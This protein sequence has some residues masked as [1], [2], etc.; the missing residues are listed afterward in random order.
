MRVPGQFDA[1]QTAGIVGRRD[2]DGV[3]QG[4]GG[5]EGFGAALGGDGVAEIGVD[6]REV[7]VQRRRGDRRPGIER[8]LPVSLPGLGT[9]GGFGRQAVRFRDEGRAEFGHPVRPHLLRPAR[10]ERHNLPATTE[11]HPAIVGARRRHQI[12]AATPTSPMPS[13]RHPSAPRCARHPPHTARR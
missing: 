7:G 11:M 3:D 12:R 4:T 2:D 10:P 9:G 13:S 6:L 5:L 8:G 1:G